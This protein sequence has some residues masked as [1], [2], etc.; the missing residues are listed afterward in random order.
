MRVVILSK[1]FVAPPAQRLLEWL[2]RQPGIDLTLV[3][4]PCWRGDDGGL[5]PYQPT[6]TAGYRVVVLPIARNGRYHLYTYRRLAAALDDLQPDLLHIDE[7]PYNLATAQA[8]RLACQRGIPAVVVAWQNLMR[9]YPPPFAWLERYV[10]RHTAA[11]IAGNAG[12]ADV[13]RD[14]G[15]RGP[16]HTFAVHGIDP[17]DWPSRLPDPPAPDASFTV[18]YI[19]RLVPEKGVDLLLHALARLPERV[20]LVVIG[21]GPAAGALR[22]LATDLDV[23]PRVTWQAYVPPLALPPAMRALDALALPSRTR[24]G[25]AEQFGRVLAEAMASGVPVIGAAIG[26]IPDVIGDAGLL[27]PDNDATALAGCIAALADDTARWRDLARRGRSRALTEFTHAR[28]AA[29][30]ADVY[31]KMLAR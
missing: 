17:A 27:F 9:C 30:L 12:A 23:A 24:P 3:T 2:A 25:W 8:V 10:Y 31:V 26:A 19:G 11:I 4:P 20:R 5:H 15:Y 7:E 28:I 29:R 16:R 18:G 1:T 22:A 13:V 14:K 6:Y 21:R